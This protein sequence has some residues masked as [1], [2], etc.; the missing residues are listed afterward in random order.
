MIDNNVKYIVENILVKNK[1]SINELSIRAAVSKQT[2]YRVLR[3]AKV[4][5][6]TSYKIL[7]FYCYV[8]INKK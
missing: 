5:Q 4:S 3:G 6:Q 1:I 2:I 7:K 8:C